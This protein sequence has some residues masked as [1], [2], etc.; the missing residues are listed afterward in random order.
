MDPAVPTF[1][2]LLASQ[3]SSF[4][5][6]SPGEANAVRQPLR[7]R[8]SRKK[9]C[10]EITGNDRCLFNRDKRKICHLIIV[11]KIHYIKS[12]RRRMRSSAG[13]VAKHNRRF[14]KAPTLLRFG[15]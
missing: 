1:S 14:T 6:N 10:M 8:A 11:S 12:D 2:P 4:L 5:A 3:P 7:Q 9:T 13:Q 15:D